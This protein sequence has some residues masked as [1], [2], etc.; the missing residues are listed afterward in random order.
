MSGQPRVLIVDDEAHAR[1]NLRLALEAL[2][3]WRVAGECASAAA[4]RAHLASDSVDVLLLD[5]QMP[6]ESGLELARELSRLDSPPLVVFVTAHRGHA[7]EAF[8]AHA[9]DYVVKPVDE[10]RL[11]QALERAGALL[12]QR[13][14]YARALRLYTDPAPGYWRS[15]TVR[16]VGR[17]DRVDLADVLWIESAGNYVSLH[18][19]QRALLHRS[20]LGELERYLDPADFLRIHR[21]ALVRRGQLLTLRQTQEG[22]YALALR[23]GQELAVSERYAAAVKAALRGS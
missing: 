19:A 20:T 11:R 18:L 6:L 12:D 4:A 7:L 22:G 3:G 23:C 15:L 8:D 14:A 2:P 5:V 17:I 16:S 10:R 1:I 13:E 21:R 9:L